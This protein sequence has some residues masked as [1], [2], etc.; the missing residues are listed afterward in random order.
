MYIEVENVIFPYL[1]PIPRDLVANIS[2]LQQLTWRPHKTKSL[3]HFE[4]TSFAR[5]IDKTL[6][7]IPSSGKLCL[8]KF[9]LD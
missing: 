4:S 2:S 1:Q 3:R 9:P 8:R 5:S 6:P 7:W